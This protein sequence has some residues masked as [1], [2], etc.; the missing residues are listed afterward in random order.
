VTNTI[1]WQDF[2]H[3]PS[4]DFASLFPK[5]GDVDIHQGSKCDFA[6]TLAGFMASLVIDVPSQAHWI[7][8]LT[9]Y[10]FGGATGHLVASVPGIHFYRTSVLSE[11]FEASPV[12]T[13]V[14]HAEILLF[15][16]LVPLPLFIFGYKLSYFCAFK[17]NICRLYQVLLNSG[18]GPAMVWWIFCQL[19]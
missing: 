15:A 10:D 2:P 19:P 17:F 1:W 3:A 4:V 11:S 12:S 16:V 13:Q 14:C 6:A 18:Y 5:I 8:Q 9:K 7:T